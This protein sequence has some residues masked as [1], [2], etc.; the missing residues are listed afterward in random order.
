WTMI[1]II[2]ALFLVLLFS[3]GLGYILS[4]TYVFFADI[5]YLFGILMT[6][7]MYLSAIFYPVDRLPLFLQKIIGFNP[8]YL[9]IFICR[10]GI[11]Y[12]RWAGLNVWLKL[13]IFAVA[14]ITIGHFFFKRKQNLVVQKL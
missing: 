14:S 7:W 5:K 1:V 4:I 13:I 12:G 8:I 9:A 2:P 10:E 6:F 3:T 11:M